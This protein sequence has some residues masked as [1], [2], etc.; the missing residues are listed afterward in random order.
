MPPHSSG[1]RGKK[2]LLR[3]GETFLFLF[4]PNKEGKGG[5]PSLSQKKKKRGVFPLSL[6][7]KKKGTMPVWRQKKRW[8]KYVQTEKKK[9]VE[10]VLSD[11]GK[12]RSSDLWLKEVKHLWSAQRGEGGSSQ[13]L[14]QKEKEVL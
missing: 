8:G 12:R 14:D 1:E 10:K 11:R 4:W 13:T 7:W 3:K 6:S 9:N 2:G 5:T